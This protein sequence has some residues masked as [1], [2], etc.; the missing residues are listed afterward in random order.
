[1]R[2]AV[3]SDVH[4]NLL[5]LETVLADIED[6]SADVVVNLGDLVSGALAPAATT[7]RL[8][9]LGQ[10]TVR[11]NHERQVLQNPYERL[12]L[13]DRLAYDQLTEAHRAWFASL[14]LTAEIASGVR[15]FHGSPYDDLVYLLDT[16]EPDGARPATE[17][18][19]T[20]RLGKYATWPLLLCGHT[21]LQRQIRLGMGAL[22]VNPGSV[23]WPAYDDDQ[24]YPHVMESG[25]PHARYAIVDN[26]SGNWEAELL[27]VEYDWEAAAKLAESNGRPDVA[28]QLRTGLAR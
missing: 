28:G 27:A 8:M 18:E 9:E 13:S 12:S 11:G 14:P 6:R 15:A 4:G 10:V 25:T 16:V 19:V 22:V 1:M 7:D 23:G 24:P 21:H 17:E 3:I 20:S 5:A 26:A 2:I